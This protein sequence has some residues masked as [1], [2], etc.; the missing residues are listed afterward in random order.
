MNFGHLEW[1]NDSM[2]IHFGQMKN[3]QFGGKQDPKHVFANPIIP[4][5]C[6]ILAVGIYYLS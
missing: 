5:N 6:P 2:V 4:E 1:E 3:V